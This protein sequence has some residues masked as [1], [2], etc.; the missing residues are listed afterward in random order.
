MKK[1]YT[2]NKKYTLFFKIAEIYY[3]QKDYANA[4]H[5]YEKYM[6]MVPKDKQLALDSDGKP[7]VGWTSLYQ[8]AERKIKEMKEE[9][10]FR[11]GIK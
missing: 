2:L 10:F 1:T 4:I 6:S 7:M 5:Y 8:I 11:H 3:K 9:N